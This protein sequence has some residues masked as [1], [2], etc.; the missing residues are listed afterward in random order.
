VRTPDAEAVLLGNH[1]SPELVEESARLAAAAVNPISDVRASAR[2]RS[3][4][5]R[6][7][8]RRALEVAFRRAVGDVPEAPHQ[9][10]TSARSSA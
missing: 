10:A 9:S 3:A 6:V 4:M 2:Y 5:A 8:V 1:H 7:V